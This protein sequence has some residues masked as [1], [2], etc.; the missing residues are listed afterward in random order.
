[1][2][3]ILLVT[4]VLLTSTS[5]L[6]AHFDPDTANEGARIN[7]RTK[8]ENKVADGQNLR[9]NISKLNALEQLIHTG[10]TQFIAA[11]NS[12]RKHAPSQALVINNDNNAVVVAKVAQKAP[13][14]LTLEHSFLIQAA[15]R[16]FMTD[17]AE[18]TL[19]NIF[20]NYA[21]DLAV[22]L[23]AEHGDK[24]TKHLTPAII[25]GVY[26][27]IE[28]CLLGAA[29]LKDLVGAVK[30]LSG[31]KLTARS[32]VSSFAGKLS[33]PV[34][35]ILR[36]K[37][38]TDLLNRRVIG[39][40]CVG[41]VIAQAVDSLNLGGI[42]RREVVERL[43]D[44]LISYEPELRERITEEI[45]LNRVQQSVLQK[46]LERP[47]ND[48]ESRREIEGVSSEIQVLELEDASERSQRSYWG[49]FTHSVWYSSETATKLKASKSKLSKLQLK[50]KRCS[51]L[52]EARKGRVSVLEKE[53]LHLTELESCQA[54]VPVENES[55]EDV[56]KM[57]PFVN[58]HFA[59][60]SQPCPALQPGVLSSM[61]NLETVGII[62]NAYL[63]LTGVTPAYHQLRVS[64]SLDEFKRTIAHVGFQVLEI[65][66]RIDDI[67][68]TQVFP[69]VADLENR[70]W[71]GRTFSYISSVVR[72]GV[73]YVRNGRAIYNHANEAHATVVGHVNWVQGNFEN[74]RHR[75][76]V[77]RMP[78]TLTWN[79][80]KFTATVRAVN[81]VSQFMT[82]DPLSQS[83]W[84]IGFTIAVF[85]E[86]HNLYPDHIPSIVD[87]CTKPLKA[88]A[89]RIKI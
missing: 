65:Q 71:F 62:P 67:Q 72:G 64:I 80:L 45:S 48:E 19:N 81:Y 32:Q 17:E 10:D 26:G 84:M 75:L 23:Y 54:L 35:D 83:N 42:I 59:R 41:P 15:C 28:D 7:Q 78:F 61:V 74:L 85:E 44:K 40:Y 4:A 31:V 70:G 53:V 69:S 1:M 43:H 3:K 24:F 9:K 27:I 14:V 33:K 52:I 57:L 73:S 60:Y 6:Q 66:N 63:R 47:S 58:G 86:Y 25:G 77:A 36:L 39:P 46:I 20:T 55:L 21:H 50:Q 38:L 88:V 37:P 89:N 8:L 76:R 68:N 29:G 11:Y 49:G 51:D 12:L 16:L 13:S 34:V 22:Q 79:T 56:L 5:L 18:R 82:G 87:I 30:Q 2:N